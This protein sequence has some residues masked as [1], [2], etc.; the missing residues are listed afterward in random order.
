MQ[1]KESLVPGDD[2]PI[3]DDVVS[4]DKTMRNNSISWKNTERMFRIKVT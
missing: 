2:V 4:V 1:V 3:G